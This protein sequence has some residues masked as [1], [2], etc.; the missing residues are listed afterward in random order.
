MKKKKLNLND[1]KVQS[2]VTS[3]E[4]QAEETVKGGFHTLEI[5]CGA[6]VGTIVCGTNNTTCCLET[7]VQL[8]C[9]G[10]YTTPGGGCPVITFNGCF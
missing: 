8:I 10:Y 9:D 6:P 3:V 7:K 2:F 4:G 1:F 5:L